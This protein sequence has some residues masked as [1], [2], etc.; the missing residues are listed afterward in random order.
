MILSRT[1]NDSVILGSVQSAGAA[2]AVIGGVLMS[3]WG[4]FKRRIHGVLLGWILASLAL[5]FL[6]VGRESICLDPSH[7]D[8][9]FVCS[10]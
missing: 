8:G 5:T 10:R 7:A 1:G 9:H 6:G 3:M 4:G 2:G